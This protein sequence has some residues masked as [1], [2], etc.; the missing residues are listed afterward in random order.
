MISCVPP[1]SSCIEIPCHSLLSCSAC[2]A[3]CLCGSLGIRRFDLQYKT[4]GE[5]PIGAYHGPKH[6]DQRLTP[7]LPSKRHIQILAAGFTKSIEPNHPHQTKP[8]IFPSRLEV[9]RPLLRLPGDGKRA[10]APFR[11]RIE[12]AIVSLAAYAVIVPNRVLP[13]R[14]LE[15]KVRIVQVGEGIRHRQNVLQEALLCGMWRTAAGLVVQS[16]KIAAAVEDHEG[17][18]ADDAG[19]AAPEREYGDP[20]RAQPDDHGEGVGPSALR[21]AEGLVVN[22][23]ERALHLAF[24]AHKGTCS[25]CHREAYDKVGQKCRKASQHLVQRTSCFHTPCGST[26]RPTTY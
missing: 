14:V 21:E 4:C 2:A 18:G 10:P 5:T 3:R 11:D 15:R 25:P 22:L 1:S 9:D 16:K 6:F 20:Q 7:I 26:T 17:G 24:E 8:I 12:R 13:V 19:V 23:L